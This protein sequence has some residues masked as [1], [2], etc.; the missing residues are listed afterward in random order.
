M[1][2]QSKRSADSR[3]ATLGAGFH[4]HL[5]ACSQ[6]L[7]SKA[8][9]AL[10]LLLMFAASMQAATTLLEYRQRV[11]RAVVVLNGVS[12]GKETEGG[13][14]IAVGQVRGL[15][16]AKETVV[17]S[18]GQW[19]VDNTWLHE[20]L[21]DYEKMPASTQRADALR[22]TTERL[23][24]LGVRLVELENSAP[25]GDARLSQNKE[26]LA[27]I[28]RRSEYQKKQAESSAL[29]RLWQRIMK[30]LSNLFPKSA[31]MSPESATT[32]SSGAQYFVVAVALAVIAYVIWK[33]A[34][35]FLVRRKAKK[36]KKRKARIVL[37]E[38]LEPDQTSGDLLA[39]AEALARAGDLRAAI[40]KGYIALLCELGDRKIIRLAQYKTNRDYLS[41]VRQ[42]A[43]LHDEMRKLTNSFE[44]HWYGFAPATETEWHTFR[45]GYQRALAADR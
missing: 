30:W 41:A 3:D 14:M 18:T 21:S 45:S 23:Q 4:P 42:I 36:K 15:L 12:S 32:V 34:P 43:P 20:A 35:R 38:R 26:R 5:T 16:P 31:P 2:F 25:T 7:L 11:E 22:R 24:A 37:G 1:N 8:I 29:A 9:Y 6:T 39:D 33:L 40:R 13:T 17:A 44:S 28:L 19:E 10:A 27:E